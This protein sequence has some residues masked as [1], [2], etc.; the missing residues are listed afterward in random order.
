MAHKKDLDAALA[1]KKA[2]LAEKLAEMHNAQGWRV[3]AQARPA[4]T[5]CETTLQFV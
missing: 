2:A 5:R 1:D 3:E 4:I